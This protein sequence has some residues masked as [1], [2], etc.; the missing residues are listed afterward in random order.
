MCHENQHSLNYKPFQIE[1]LQYF[2]LCKRLIL[3]VKTLRVFPMISIN[4]KLTTVIFAT[5]FFFCP[6][7]ANQK[8][9]V[10]ITG[11][12]SGENLCRWF[13]NKTKLRETHTLTM[14]AS[15]PL[16]KELEASPLKDFDELK[17]LTLLNGIGQLVKKLISTYSR[18]QH[19]ADIISNVAPE[20]LILIDFPWVNLRLAKIIKKKSPKTFITYIAP[21]ELWFWGTWGI[22]S[23]LK[24]YCDEVIVIYPQEQK[25]YAKLGLTV[26]WLGYP[27]A[28]KFKN[29]SKKESKANTLALLPGSRKFEVEKSLPLMCET[30]QKCPSA[31]EM[32]IIVV[33]ASSIDYND[34]KEILEL[35][36]LSEKIKIVP[37]DDYESLSSCFYAL[38]KP[39]TITLELALLGIPHAVIM[40]HSFIN[41]MIL[42]YVINPQ[43]LGLP[44]L[45]SGE[46]ICEEF[47]QEQAT[48]ENIATHLDL[49]FGSF[50]NNQNSYTLLRE[51]MDSLRK[52][53]IDC[54]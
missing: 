23:Y 28:E 10:V 53:I 48:P 29:L 35:H 13:L 42:K 41:E 16:V 4:K 36:N 3:R 46:K 30:I 25:W 50:K 33:A 49:I 8:H 7:W 43:S 12:L 44:N 32:N 45:L 38:T 26:H 1:R 5:S 27:Y 20:K 9:A 47:V 2:W 31:N 34:I 11:E 40:K 51:K 6:L 17:E 15:T 18:F 19:L 21:P 24:K 52:K 54:E 22:D 14:L 39:G 37:Q